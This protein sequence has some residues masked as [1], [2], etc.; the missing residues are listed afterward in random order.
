MKDDRRTEPDGGR[1]AGTGGDGSVFPAEGQPAPDLDLEFEEHP[2][3]FE[4][5]YS[6]RIATDHPDL[7]DQSADW[8]EDQLGVLNL[9][10]VDFRILIADGPLNEQVKKGL[11]AWWAERVGDLRTE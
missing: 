1:G 3:G 11:T 5:R 9:G 6:D 7:V 4:I 8:L 10:Q 2:G